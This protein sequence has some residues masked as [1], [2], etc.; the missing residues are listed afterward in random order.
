MKAVIDIL[1]IPLS[2]ALFIPVNNYFNYDF[3][4]KY[5]HTPKLVNPTGKIMF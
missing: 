1:I 4:Q 5:C 2:V 3:R